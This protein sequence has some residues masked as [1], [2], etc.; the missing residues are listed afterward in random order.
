MTPPRPKPDPLTMVSFALLGLLVVLLLWP[1][2]SGSRPPSPYLVGG[3]L[4]V[5]LG[6]QVL[7]ARSDQR[8][9]RPANWALDLLLIALIFYVASNAPPA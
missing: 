7:R 2:L 9:K 8:L 4:L 1:L 6:L 3:L 5:R